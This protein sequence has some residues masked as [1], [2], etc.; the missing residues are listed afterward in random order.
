MDETE[1]S[2]MAQQERLE[3]LRRIQLGRQDR[4][5]SPKN[6]IQR[7][8]QREYPDMDRMQAE[9]VTRELVLAPKK[10][11][12]KIG[13]DEIKV[14]DLQFQIAESLEMISSET[15]SSQEYFSW[16]TESSEIMQH[17]NDGFVSEDDLKE[18]NEWIEMSYSREAEILTCLGLYQGSAFPEAKKKYAEIYNKLVKLRQIRNAIKESTANKADKPQ[19]VDIKKKENDYKKA[20]VYVAAM[21]EFMKRP[22]RWNMPKRTLQKL[23]MYH[24]D[25]DDLD[26]DYDDFYEQYEDDDL[27]RSDEENRIYQGEANEI[28]ELNF[29]FND[30]L[31]EEILFHWDDD[32]MQSYE[33]SAAEEFIEKID[34]AQPA[35]QT[36][37]DILDHI[38][39][40][41]G[42]RPPL[43]NRPSGY[44]MDRARAFSSMH[45]NSLSATRRQYA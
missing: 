20:V 16:F 28:T 1:K 24:G 8:V 22:P 29:S 36:E 33:R 17:M 31:K 39:R 38:A 5:D 13:N 40:L 30:S 2:R 21:R 27:R 35:L 10:S 42:R 7:A 41:S 34:E 25:D 44:T 14:A 15:S 43:K 19:E 12:I 32:R 18:R 11:T 9:K 3:R 26:D 4:L 37:E 23:N 6:I 45:Y